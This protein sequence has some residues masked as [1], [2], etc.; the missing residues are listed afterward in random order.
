[1][2]DKTKIRLGIGLAGLCTFAGSLLLISKSDK[3]G[4]PAD[5]LQPA[6]GTNESLHLFQ[7]PDPDPSVPFIFE[8]EDEEE[9]DGETFMPQFTPPVQL[10]QTRTRAS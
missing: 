3:A 9:D 10:P 1:M 2:N 4:M 5:M 8:H 6:F 7:M